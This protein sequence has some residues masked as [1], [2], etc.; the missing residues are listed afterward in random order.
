MACGEH[1][2]NA[3]VASVAGD[4]AIDGSVEGAWTDSGAVVVRKEPEPPADLVQGVRGQEDQGG[5]CSAYGAGGVALGGRPRVDDRR[6]RARA[7]ASRDA[8]REP[9]RGK[10]SFQPGNCANGTEHGARGEGGSCIEDATKHVRGDRERLCCKVDPHAE[11]TECLHGFGCASALGG[12]HQPAEA[13][14][15]CDEALRGPEG[16]ACRSGTKDDVV[17]V[18]Q[19]I[20]TARQ[21]EVREA[22]SRKANGG[23]DLMPGDRKKRA[24]WPIILV[25]SQGAWDRPKGKTSNL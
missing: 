18:L 24:Q 10:E 2:A 4:I 3:H 13:A 22:R 20:Q 21:S 23:R 17:E 25:N 8:R 9:G 15:D 14:E 1:C 6:K 11:G 5:P 12:M 16:V 7:N 19:D